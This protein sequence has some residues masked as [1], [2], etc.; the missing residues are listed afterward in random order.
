M[1]TGDSSS[2]STAHALSTT[3]AVPPI[4]NDSAIYRVWILRTH[5][6]WPLVT[7]A[8][9]EEQFE[10]MRQRNVHNY[11]VYL[12]T[13]EWRNVL[14]TGVTNSLERRV[15]QHKQGEIKG[16]TRQYN[17]HLLVLVE[18]YLQ[19]SDAIAREKQIKGW[20]RAKKNALVESKNPKWQDLAAT[21]YAA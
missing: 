19:I 16:F 18:N 11:Y 1:K 2:R 21:W 7:A 15:W 17:C 14:Y 20:S 5:A 4:R 13:N 8:H 12:M 9:A 6:L 3:P 10:S